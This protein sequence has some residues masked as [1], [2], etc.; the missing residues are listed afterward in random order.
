MVPQLKAHFPNYTLGLQWGQP[1]GS[2]RPG[3]C[4]QKQF[5]ASGPQETRDPPGSREAVAW[6]TYAALC[7]VEMSALHEVPRPGCQRWLGFL[8]QGFCFL[9]TQR[10]SLHC[11]WLINGLFGLGF[12]VH[13]SSQLCDFDQV[14]TSL[15]LIY[16]CE[17]GMIILSPLGATMRTESKDVCAATVTPCG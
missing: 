17:M 11:S 14:T 15:S 12:N 2:L 3:R 8:S 16:A 7:G 13:L 6:S 4:L 5:P 10:W 1:G 9:K